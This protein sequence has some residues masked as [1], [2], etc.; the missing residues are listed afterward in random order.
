MRGLLLIIIS[1]FAFN[2]AEAQL[3]IIAY[4]MFH[5]KEHVYYKTGGTIT[6][7]EDSII[8]L[9]EDPELAMRLGKVENYNGY[10]IGYLGK[11]RKRVIVSRQGNVIF[12]L[13]KKYHYRLYLKEN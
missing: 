1:I 7:K 13:W 2:I 9:I 4:E 3:E 10:Y 5:K 12:I 11:S 6:F 8:S